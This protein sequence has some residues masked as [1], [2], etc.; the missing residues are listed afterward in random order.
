[1]MCM[2]KF[3]PPEHPNRLGRTNSPKIVIV[4]YMPNFHES[5]SATHFAEYYARPFMER[6]NLKY[7]TDG[8]K[9]RLE[10][11]HKIV[12]EHTC[13]STIPLTETAYGT[14]KPELP[15]DNGY[16]GYTP[17]VALYHYDIEKYAINYMICINENWD[18]ANDNAAKVIAMDMQTLGIKPTSIVRHY[19][20]TGRLC[21]TPF[22]EEPSNWYKFLES[23]KNYWLEMYLIKYPLN[24][25]KTGLIKDKAELIDVFG[26]RKSI[27]LAETQEVFILGCSLAGSCVVN[28]RNGIYMTNESYVFYK[29]NETTEIV[30]EPEEMKRKFGFWR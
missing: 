23:V 20:I 30:K 7:E 24:R 14:T 12:D 15:I 25:N 10:S 4:H 18:T 29:E 8:R 27:T 19:D 1:M 22:I 9:F 16:K 17:T 5:K 6:T 26:L 21:P 28:Y 13:V 11:Y 2:E 3:I